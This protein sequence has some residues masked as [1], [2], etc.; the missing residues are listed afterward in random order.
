MAGA[1][2]TVVC[3]LKPM[4]IADVTLYNEALNSYLREQHLRGAAGFGC[5]TQIRLSYL[6]S[7][8]YHVKP[9][10][11]S[12]IDRTYACA[13]MGER[14]PCPTPW[15]GFIP[16]QNRRRWESEWPVVGGLG[17]GGQNRIHG[18]RW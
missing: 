16:D 4:Q 8:G 15:E 7:D 11:D 9:D 13:I 17:S 12:T 1:A 6:K 18:W 5:R 10:Y 2:A 3:Q 14:V